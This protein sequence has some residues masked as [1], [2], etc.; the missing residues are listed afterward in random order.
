MNPMIVTSFILAV[1]M[2]LFIWNKLPAAVVAVLSLLALYLT[3]VL[4]MPISGVMSPAMMSC[5]RRLAARSLSVSLC[6]TSAG[7]LRAAIDID[8]PS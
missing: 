6:D 8:S 2:V 3:G 5:S 7:L 4:T 1:T